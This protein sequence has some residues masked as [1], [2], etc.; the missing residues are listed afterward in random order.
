MAG[1]EARTRVS[2][3][4]S[5]GVVQWHVQ[6]STDKHTLALDFALGAQVGETKDV[7]GGSLEVL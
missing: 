1:T 6:V 5:P 2:S 7:H 4:I 3:V